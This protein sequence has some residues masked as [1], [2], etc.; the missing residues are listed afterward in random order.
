MTGQIVFD[1]FLF[2]NTVTLDLSSEIV[3]FLFLNCAFANDKNVERRLPA[4]VNF[5][6]TSV[7]FSNCEFNSR[8]IEANRGTN[9]IIK[10]T[11]FTV[12]IYFLF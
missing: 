10:D 8:G 6:R 3:K 7:E 12:K 5:A 4:V 9:L 2:E 11:T 1:G